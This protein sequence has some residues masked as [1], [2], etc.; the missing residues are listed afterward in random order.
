MSVNGLWPDYEK[1]L[2]TAAIRYQAFIYPGV[3]HGFNNDT[4]P[5]FDEAWQRT[6]ALF[7]RTLA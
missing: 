2:K 7:K 1:A 5:R 3:E 6:L 4:T